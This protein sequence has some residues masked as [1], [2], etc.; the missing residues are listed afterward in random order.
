MVFIVINVERTCRVSCRFPRGLPEEV[1]I[2]V[3]VP[4]GIMGRAFGA[5]CQAVHLQTVV[6]LCD[7][8]AR[9]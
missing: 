3:D 1:E 2:F 8:D 4:G 5:F 7:E 6:T 9:P